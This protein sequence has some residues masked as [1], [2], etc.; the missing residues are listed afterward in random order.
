M[1]RSLRI[2]PRLLGARG[3]TPLDVASAAR[4][5]AMLSQLAASR[6]DVHEMEINPLLVTAEG[7][8]ALD[9]RLVTG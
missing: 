5:A 4:V 7:A 3:A 9:A 6:P 2:A 8:I 1:I